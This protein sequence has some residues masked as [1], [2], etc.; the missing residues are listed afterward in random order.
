[1][2]VKRFYQVLNASYEGGIAEFASR[3][4]I[5]HPNNS[6]ETETAYFLREMWQGPGWV[7]NLDAAGTH[8]LLSNGNQKLWPPIR[9]H[10]P[11]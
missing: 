4:R 3:R 8:A 2:K 5:P 6:S 1:M 10:V 7:I 11:N 9:V